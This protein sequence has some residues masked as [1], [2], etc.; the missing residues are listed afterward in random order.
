M[1]K[2]GTKRFIK[3]GIVVSDI[4]D[5][6][7]RYGELFNLDKIPEAHGYEPAKGEPMPM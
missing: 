5:A 2:M 6:A 7:R 4:E 3:I 1:D